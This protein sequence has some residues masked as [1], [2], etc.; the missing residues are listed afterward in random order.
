MSGCTEQGSYFC[1]EDPFD[2]HVYPLDRMLLPQTLKYF[3]FHGDEIRIVFPESIW[4][5]SP[6]LLVLGKFP[7]WFSIIWLM[8][9]CIFF[10]LF[11]LLLDWSGSLRTLCV[12]A[13]I[14]VLCGCLVL[15]S[16]P[17]CCITLSCLHPQPIA[18]D[19]ELCCA[20]VN[21]YIKK[22]GRGRCDL[23]R[24]LTDTLVSVS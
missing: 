16:S 8:T 6:I 19:G 20:A 9:L 12:L 11:F 5:Y 17:G 4:S 22:A 14:E 18:P 24:A 2:A 23:Y 1:S 3:T 13:P 15:Y 21:Q 10:Y 7:C